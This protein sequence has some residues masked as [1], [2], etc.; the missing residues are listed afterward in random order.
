M[1]RKQRYLFADKGLYGQGCG[2]SSSHVCMGCESWTIKKAERWRIDAFKLWHWR[3][4]L[5]VPWTARRSNQSI[6]K[7]IN[8]EYSLEGLM[9]KLQYFRATWCEEPTHWKRGWLM[10]GKIEG[11]RRRGRQRMTWLDDITDSMD[12][13][14][15]KL[16]EV[17]KDRE[18]WRATVRGVEKSRIQ[19]GDW[20]TA[21]VDSYWGLNF[22]LQKAYVRT[23]LPASRGPK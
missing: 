18:V 22:T 6:L 5:R 10:L 4:L 11:K 3:S 17:M 14:L 1:F 9:L 2:F 15:S 12:M 20:T 19:L 7:G 16:Q 13:S 23:P 8:P 21:A